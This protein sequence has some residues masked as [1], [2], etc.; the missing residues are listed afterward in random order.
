MNLG[1]FSGERKC[2]IEA[3]KAILQ[4]YTKKGSFMKPFVITKEP[5]ENSFLIQP[6]GFIF[7][8][9]RCC[10]EHN[11]FLDSGGFYMNLVDKN[12]FHMVRSFPMV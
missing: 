11:I 9:I 2:Y 8:Y 12:G 5:F 7:R 10:V 3:I 4:P 6:Y 1:S